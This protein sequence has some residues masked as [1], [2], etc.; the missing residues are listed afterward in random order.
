MA[1]TMKGSALRSWRMP[2]DVTIC[3]LDRGTTK[4]I[5][6]AAAPIAGR[7]VEYRFLE[8]VGGTAQA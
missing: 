5:G 3:Y 1:E 4:G 2:A 7:P 6:V 8:M